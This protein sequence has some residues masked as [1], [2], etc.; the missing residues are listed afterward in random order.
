MSKR[1]NRRV[2]IMD[3]HHKVIVSNNTSSLSARTLH[4]MGLVCPLRS[5]LAMQLDPGAQKATEA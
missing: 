3:T 1:A 4:T 2:Q 5:K